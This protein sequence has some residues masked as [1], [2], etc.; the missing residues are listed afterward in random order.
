M[1][2]LNSY[3]L[4]VIFGLISAG[5][6]AFCKHLSNQLKDYK[7]LLEKREN[8]IVS[9]SIDKK[10][11]PIQKEI[12]ELKAYID[13]VANKGD[14][15]R[16]ETVA[17]WG[18]RIAQLCEIYFNQGFMTHSQYI[19]LVEMYNLYSELGGNGKIKDIFTTTTQ[20]LDIRE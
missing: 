11:E 10:L 13:E 15:L 16:T 8:D 5:L 19:Q 7:N 20:N 9:D 6:L 12:K 4:N 2:N 18:F 14:F 17:A 1:P 3:I